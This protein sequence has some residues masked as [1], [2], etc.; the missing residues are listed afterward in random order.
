MSLENWIPDYPD[1]MTFLELYV[2]DGSHNN[3]GWSN[4]EY[5]SIIKAADSSLASNPD[6]R[7]SE[8]QRAEG[9]LL[10]EAGIVPLYQ[11]GVAQLQ[12]L[13]LKRSEP[14]IRRRFYIKRSLY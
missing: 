3:T 5:D 13:T 7:L 14:P 2:T 9:M 10:N 12:N 11:V 8:L 6:K 1:P 4:K